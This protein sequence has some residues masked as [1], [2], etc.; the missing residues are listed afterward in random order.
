MLTLRAPPLQELTQSIACLDDLERYMQ[1]QSDRLRQY[2][3]SV[4][5]NLRNSFE[6]EALR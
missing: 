2:S 3:L 4:L 5:H 6:C 1:A